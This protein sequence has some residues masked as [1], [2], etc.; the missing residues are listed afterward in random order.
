MITVTN[1][2]E[3]IKIE[4]K[5]LK[6]IK[7]GYLIVPLNDYWMINL[8]IIID[9]N[10]ITKIIKTLPKGD[11][12]LDS[13]IN[14]EKSKNTVKLTE[15]DYLNFKKLYKNMQDKN[16]LK[17]DIYVDAIAR[18]LAYE[19]YQANVLEDYSISM[20]EIFDNEFSD[21]NN[22]KKYR[23]EIINQAQDYFLKY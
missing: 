3:S 17:K 13:F 4:N 18:I 23:L 15:K 22:Y 19:Y 7:Q 1:G 5:Y 12:V 21:F 14:Q 2:L 16:N 6:K 8:K 10:K 9:K 20:E 11:N